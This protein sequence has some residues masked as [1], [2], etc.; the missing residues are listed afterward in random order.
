MTSDVGQS[1]ETR[2][3][4][5]FL[6]ELAA[7]VGEEWPAIFAARE[8]ARQHESK[9]RSLVAQ[10]G[11]PSGTSV[12][13]F[14]SLAR[15]EW[16]SG[17][18]VDWTLLIDGPSDVSHFYVAKEVGDLL[19]GNGYLKPGPT[20]TFGA[21][22]SS[23][24]LVHHIGG[25]EDTNQNITRRVLLLLESVSL[26]DNITH[27]RV[28]R[29]ILERYIIGDP[30]V[31]TPAKF[32]VP[33]FLLNDVVRFWRTMAVD[34]ATKKWQRLNQGWA[35][36]NVK[37]RMSR[38]LLFAKGLLMCF[39]CHR[40]FAGEPKNDDPDQ[41]QLE[42]LSHCLRLSRTPAMELL[43]EAFLEFAANETTAQSA[44]EAARRTINAYD[45]FLE[46][47]DDPARR[48]DLADLDLE[49]ADDE[50]FK[51]QRRNTGNFRDG[52]ETLFFYSDDRLTR[53][54]R[55]YGVF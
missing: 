4:R 14:G 1:G 6:K 30:P 50:L 49:E 19:Q 42:L 38:K 20:G 35:L 10:L 29:S 44:N 15:E 11:P 9:L 33:M 40:D 3:S 45:F 27:Q 8:R 5:D 22:S 54:T 32:R 12:I 48:K 13:A 2:G 55:K 21:M 47:M 41:V 26:S 52:L 16:T 46:T 51:E 34:Y 24:E 39:L 37:L 7:L 43:A 53:L 23:H 25:T 36:R 18:D 31:S 17:S 28:L